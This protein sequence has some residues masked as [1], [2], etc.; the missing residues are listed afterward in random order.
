MRFR[1]RSD[2]GQQLAAALLE[3]KNDHPIVMALPRGGV[4]VGAEVA[5]ALGAPLGIVLVRKI[6]APSQPELA[7][8]AVVDGLE[9]VVV[10]NPHVL[11]W[12]G[13]SEAEFK[14]ICARELREIERRRD[15][16]VGKRP[17]LEPSG[18]VTIVVDDGVATGATTRVALKAMRMHNPKRLILA[19]PVGAASAIDELRQVADDVVCLGDL[20]PYGAVGYFY[21]DFEQLTDDDVT[22]ILGRF[23]SPKRGDPPP[24]AE[25]SSVRRITGDIDDSKIAAILAIEPSVAELEEAAGWSRGE[26]NLLGESGHVLHG[27]VAAIFDILTADDEDDRR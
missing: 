1:D 2:A 23:S 5:R 18:R 6:G 27:K 9:P 14:A 7:L 26:G 11:A 22:G 20:E 4:P 13:T 17:S 25:V 21:D 8:G 3:Y 16:F 15:A 24:A 19:V 10:R 12:T